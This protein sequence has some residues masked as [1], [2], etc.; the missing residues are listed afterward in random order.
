MDEFSVN[1][2]N[3]IKAGVTAI[4][5]RGWSVMREAVTGPLMEDI[6]RKMAPIVQ[7]PLTTNTVIDMSWS[8]PDNAGSDIISY[9]VKIKF[10]Y[11]NEY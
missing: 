4:N 7:G 6:P 9:I 10:D 11:E 3:M 2:G 1:Y 5:D 8:E